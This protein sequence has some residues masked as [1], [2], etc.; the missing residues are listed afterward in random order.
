[1]AFNDCGYLQYLEK[2]SGKTLNLIVTNENGKLVAK[3][4][5]EMESPLRANTTIGLLKL[6]LQFGISKKESDLAKDENDFERQK[7]QDEL[8]LLK[9]AK[10]KTDGKNVLIEFE[11]PSD[12]AKSFLER[13]INEV[14]KEEDTAATK[15][16]NSQV[17]STKNANANTVR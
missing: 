2:F 17:V 10:V 11:F 15:T 3:A 7:D 13:K 16:P 4:V 5:A 6:A 14:D 12:F 1:M 8:M 9:T